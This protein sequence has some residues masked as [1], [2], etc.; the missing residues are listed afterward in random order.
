MRA[1]STKKLLCGR[2]RFSYFKHVEREHA[3]LGS[4]PAYWRR[5]VHRPSP[6]PPMGTPALPSEFRTPG[7]RHG[8]GNVYIHPGRPWIAFGRAVGPTLG[9]AKLHRHHSSSK[10]SNSLPGCHAPLQIVG[11]FLNIIH[12]AVCEVLS[13][14]Y[15]PTL[16]LVRQLRRV[17]CHSL[18]HH[19]HIP[20][21]WIFLHAVIRLHLQLLQN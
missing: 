20:A 8:R 6:G 18:F 3:R 19:K 16:S 13:C 10:F 1:P 11:R 4:V 2:L 21:R 9:Q 14:L 7:P 15:P 12:P 17:A 5:P